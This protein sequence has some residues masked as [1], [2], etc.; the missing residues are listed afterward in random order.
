MGGTGQ[1]DNVEIDMVA[2]VPDSVSDMPSVT[3]TN[4]KYHM[5]VLL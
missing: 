3:R 5:D 2:G 1:N 4:L